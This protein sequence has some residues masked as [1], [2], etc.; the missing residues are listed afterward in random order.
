MK[1]G[2][3]GRARLEHARQIIPGVTQLLSKRP[4]QFGLEVWPTYFARAR[5]SRVWDLDGQCFLDMS[6]SGIGANVLGYS[7]PVVN[8]AVRRAIRRG[9]SSSL[10]CAEEVQLSEELLRLH[11]WAEKARFARTG[12]EAMAIAVRIARAATGRDKV[13]FCGYHGWHDWYLAANLQSKDSLQPHLLPGLEPLGVPEALAGTSIPFEFGNLEQLRGLL[14][15]HSGEVAAIVMEPTRKVIPAAGYLQ[16]VQ[17]M[18]AQ[19]NAVLIFDEISSGFR[20]ELGGIHLSYGVNP[21][22]AVFGK[23]ISNGFAM[24]A[25]IGKASVMDSVSKSF[26]SSTNW[27][28][29]I[30]PVAALAT[31]SRLEKLNAFSR[32]ESIGKSV[33]E[34]WSTQA[35]SNGLTL[36]I[37]GL[38][39]MSYLEFLDGKPNAV[40]TFYIQEMLRSG[41][42]ASTRF[43]ANV[44]QTRKDLQQFEVAVGKAF[45]LIRAALDDSSLESKTFSP[46]IPIGFRRL[47]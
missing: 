10:N 7:D 17:L 9:V 29:R 3:Q 43:Y 23:A 13:L 40:A 46:T 16:Q 42:L 44:A 28:E 30:G 39:A 31:I 20:Y 19:F 15:E 25:V 5:K 36:R 14:E 33:Q 38:P 35:K 6:I 47:N 22:I 12:G 26:I 4:D 45:S 34:I 2:Q 37:S 32:L 27:T 18:A 41:I 11:P 24:A 1:I 21:D 8:A